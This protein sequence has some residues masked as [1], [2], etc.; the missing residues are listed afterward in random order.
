MEMAKVNDTF[1]FRVRDPNGLIF[2][3]ADVPMDKLGEVRAQF[4]QNGHSKSQSTPDYEGFK[5]KLS[6]NAKKFLRILRD[7]QAGITADFLAEKMGFKSGTQIGGM[8]GGG[9]SKNANKFHIELSDI[10]TIEVDHPGGERVTTYKPGKE[11]NR[12]L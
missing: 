2:E 4:S 7:N 11:I 8:T 9:L 12:V 6:D 10:Y 5:K 3:V 1:T